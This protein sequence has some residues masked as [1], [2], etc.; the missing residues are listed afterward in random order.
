MPQGKLGASA[1]FNQQAIGR[2]YKEEKDENLIFQK[3]TCQTG[4]CITI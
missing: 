3:Q 2:V 1:P 4:V